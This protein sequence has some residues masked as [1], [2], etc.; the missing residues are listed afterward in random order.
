MIGKSKEVEQTN[1][2]KEK[3]CR[4]QIIRRNVKIKKQAY[5]YGSEP[6]G[7]IKI[8]DPRVQEQE[9]KSFVESVVACPEP[10]H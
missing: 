4:H 5:F 10:S 3:T 7:K 1:I 2:Q 9:Q 6:K 8:L